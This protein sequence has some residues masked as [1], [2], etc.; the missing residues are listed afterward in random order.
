M[1]EIMG[2]AETSG[3]ENQEKCIKLSAATAVKSV[4]CLLSQQ[5]EDRCIAGTVSQNTENRDSNFFST[6][7][8]NNR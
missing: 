3:P 7:T 4:K 5:K 2:T 1:T 6:G 8:K